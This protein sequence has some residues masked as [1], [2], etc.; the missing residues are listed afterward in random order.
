[1]VNGR[2]FAR[3]WSLKPDGWYHAF[4]RDPLGTLQVGTR[5]MRVRAVRVRGTR[6]NAAIERAYAEKFSTPSSLKYV[7]GFKSL[8]RRKTTT[9]FVPR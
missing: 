5:A 8:K 7:R 6:L 3:S 9:E 2:V 4:L 1:V